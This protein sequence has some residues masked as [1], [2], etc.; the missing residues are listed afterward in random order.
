[1]PSSRQIAAETYQQLLAHVPMLHRLDETEQQKI[2]EILHRGIVRQVLRDIW[3]VW[4]YDGPDPREALLELVD[5]HAVT[6]GSDGHP[7]TANTSTRYWR[8]WYP[9]LDN[10]DL[11]L[12]EV[13]D[14]LPGFTPDEVPPLV[15]LFENP[16]SPVA[17]TGACTLGQHD[18]IHVLLGRG[19]VDQDE[20]FTIGFT[21]GTSK[22]RLTESEKDAYRVALQAY[23]EPY[24]IKG[25][26]LLA[27]DL[28]VKAGAICPCTQIHTLDLARCR[29]R[30]L[31]EL[32]SEL[33]IDIRLLHD[34]Y[35]LEQRIIPGTPASLRLPVGP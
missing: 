19:L 18:A 29:P 11:T 32:R 25:K 6:T 15:R 8:E 12:G 31:Q 20:A 34:F 2:R 1:M 26:D 24:R 16:A 17:L 10:G 30:R 14:T 21:A 5:P 3:Q 27:F 35:R 23:E 7:M 13:M 22:Q 9:G 33:G 28:G 4:N